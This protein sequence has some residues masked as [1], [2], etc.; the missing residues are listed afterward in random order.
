MQRL[1]LSGGGGC[2]A[3]DREP[4]GSGS[5]EAEP[6]QDGTHRG[7]GDEVLLFCRLVGEPYV[8]CGRLRYVSHDARRLPVKFVWNL[9]DIQQL[10][11]SEAFQ[12]ILSVK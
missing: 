8:C 4:S 9:A 1:I 2:S 10:R 12:S 5:Q 6:S 11:K 3:A 7:S